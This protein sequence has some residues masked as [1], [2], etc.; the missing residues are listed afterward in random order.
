MAKNAATEAAL[1][2]LHDKVAVVFR[3]VLERYE[4]RLDAIDSIDVESEML[5]ELFD[6]G[7]MPSPAML[8]AVTKFLKDNEIAFATEQIDQLTAQQRRLEENKKKRGNV[9]DLSTLHA[10]GE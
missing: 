10:I 1:G 6:E 4:A 7:A 8:S 5:Q 2:S 9:V 3:K